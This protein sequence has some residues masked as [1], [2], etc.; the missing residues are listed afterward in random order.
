MPAKTI[1]KRVVLTLCVLFMLTSTCLAF[2]PF[3]PES[4]KKNTPRKQQVK[5]ERHETVRLKQSQFVFLG[6]AAGSYVVRDKKT[7]SVFLW[8][9]GE[10]IGN[11]TIKKRRII[12]SKN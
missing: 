6:T 10:R 9:E 3:L 2:N 11:C 4:R 1:A 7:G 5:E 12:C 8:K